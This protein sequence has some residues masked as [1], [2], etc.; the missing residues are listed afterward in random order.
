MDAL[1][2]FAKCLCVTL[3]LYAIGYNVWAIAYRVLRS[4]F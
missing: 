1:R 3:V 4:C 2:D